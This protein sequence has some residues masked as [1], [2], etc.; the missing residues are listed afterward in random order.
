MNSNPPTT[1]RWPQLGLR[2]LLLAVAVAGIWL[3]DFVNRREIGRLEGKV[4]SQRTAARVFEVKDSNALVYLRVNPLRADD[5]RWDIH[6]PSGQ[7][8]LVL[9][10]KNF[11]NSNQLPPGESIVL[12]AGRSRVVLDSQD[13]D[14]TLTAS[15]QLNGK[16]VLTAQQ[17]YKA[18]AIPQRPER[19]GS[20]EAT[21][22]KGNRPV[23]LHRLRH[24]S[25]DTGLMLWIE[26]AVN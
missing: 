21:H 12:P 8:R 3:A 10:T 11:P 19:L 25:G 17:T 14:G 9:A 15:A 2:T 4:K 13:V 20:R 1:R 24:P 7:F 5:Y 6:V 22:E 18:T 16:T 23:M 26:P